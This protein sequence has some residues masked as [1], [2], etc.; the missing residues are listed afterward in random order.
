MRCAP[1]WTAKV[2]RRLVN[3]CSPAGGVDDDIPPPATRLL[4]CTHREDK[5]TTK[6]KEGYW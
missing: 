1:V 3:A 5:G 6:E 4:A 2:S